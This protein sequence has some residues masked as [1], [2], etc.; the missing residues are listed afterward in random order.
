VSAFY[1][2]TLDLV[3]VEEAPTHDLL[4]GP[5]VELVIHAISAEL[6]VRHQDWA[7]ASHA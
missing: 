3:A 2:R 1:Q 4:K 5:G 7:T 6:R